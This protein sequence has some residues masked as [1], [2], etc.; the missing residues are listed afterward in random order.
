MYVACTHPLEAMSAWLGPT[1]QRLDTAPHADLRK[2][3]TLTCTYIQP[4]I[5]GK[6][7]QRRGDTVTVKGRGLSEEGM[8]CVGRRS[9]IWSRRQAMTPL[10]RSVC[11]WIVEVVTCTWLHARCH[12][13][14]P[15]TFM[16]RRITG[17]APCRPTTSCETTTHITTIAPS[18]PAK[19]Y[20][21]SSGIY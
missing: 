1:W 6:E 7:G 16:P 8:T 14:C 15:L 17:M 12:V 18:D 4:H 9:S 19:Q 5:E 20:K 13:L 11:A 3:G 2:S 10:D 21:D